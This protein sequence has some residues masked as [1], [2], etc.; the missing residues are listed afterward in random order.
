MFVFTIN[1]TILSVLLNTNFCNYCIFD[2]DW[3]EKQQCEEL[4]DSL[5][6]DY[7]KLEAEYQLQQSVFKKE[8]ESTDK[9]RLT[10]TYIIYPHVH[11]HTHIQMQWSLITKNY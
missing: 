4:Y 5:S 8:R 6:E 11:A 10:H 7:K 3:Q 1:K 9:V 2:C